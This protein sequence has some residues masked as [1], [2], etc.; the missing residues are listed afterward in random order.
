MDP[1]EE[2]LFEIWRRA[3]ELQKAG[4]LREALDLW[5]EGLDLKQDLGISGAGDV[6]ELDELQRRIHELERL[7][8]PS[9]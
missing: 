6:G 7:L 5:R 9:R 3:P 2:R 4:Q 8:A 1:R